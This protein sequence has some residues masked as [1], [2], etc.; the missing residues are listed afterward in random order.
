MGILG[1][2]HSPG[3]PSLAWLVEEGGETSRFSPLGQPRSLPSPAKGNTTVKLA[4]YFKLP[5]IAHYL[6]VDPDAAMVVH[7]SRRKGSDILT[8]VVTDGCLTLDPPGLE[9]ALTDI[10]SG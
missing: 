7:R 6:T 9:L 2:A 1:T 10:Y 4:G 5:S 8:R 3:S